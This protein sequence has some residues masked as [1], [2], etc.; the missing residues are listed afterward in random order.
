MVR[1]T[2]RRSAL[3]LA[4]ALV[5][6]RGSGEP[7]PLRAYGSI[8]A[9]QVRVSSRVPG[10]VLRVLV[11]ENDAVVPGQPLLELD[12]HELEARRDQARA[13]LA[14]ALAR[15]RLLRHG[16]RQ[17]DVVA[18]QKA[19][20]AARLRAEQARHDR[21]RADMLRASNA[22][23]PSAHEAARTAFEL[24]TTEVATRS[25]E[26]QK[27][28]KG[29]RAEELEEAAAARDEAGAALAVIEEQ[30]ND[31]ILAAPLAGTVIHRLVEPGEVVRPA[32]PLLVIGDL[33][34]PYMDV[35]VPE[36]RLAEARLG[37]AAEVEVD[38][39]PG[40]VLRAT[41]THVSAEAEFTPKNVQTEEQRARLVF[42]VRVTVEDPQGLLRPGMPGAAVFKSPGSRD[43]RDGGPE[44][45][46][47]S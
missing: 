29:A 32:A 24:A 34:R 17:E 5:S 27:I 41:V 46:R 23:S 4:L 31:R 6:C 42:R 25:A 28:V 14:Q 16:A 45:R 11:D 7:I 33:A 43:S 8:E 15:E 20:A 40:R 30:L 21:D 2:P 39:F 35:Y 22:I 38:A 36:P 44:P 18:A 1:T 19:I 10:R 9:R 26:L 13:V 47:K 12:L 3:A 37:T